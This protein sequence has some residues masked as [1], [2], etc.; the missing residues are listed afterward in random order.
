MLCDAVLRTLA[1]LL[2]IINL[3]NCAQHYCC[4][5]LL[6]RFFIT[7]RIARGLSGMP[8]VT[9]LVYWLDSGV[10][11]RPILDEVIGVE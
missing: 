5:L 8:S 3:A 4:L 2:L 7:V 1:C 6:F 11:D 9:I 10:I